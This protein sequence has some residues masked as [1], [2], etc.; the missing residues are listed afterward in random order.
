[1]RAP[2]FGENVPALQFVQADMPGYWPNLLISRC[3]WKHVHWSI[4]PGHNLCNLTELFR[5]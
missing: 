4:Y 3:I 2:E 1:M 5:V